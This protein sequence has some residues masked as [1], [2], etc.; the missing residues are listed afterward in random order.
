[1]CNNN[2]WNQVDTMQKH[3]FTNTIYQEQ[4]AEEFEKPRHSFFER[5]VYAEDGQR[6]SPW[7]NKVI[8]SHTHQQYQIAIDF[9]VINFL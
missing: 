5:I 3:D 2:R 9:L 8:K 4:N 1:M 7:M 6:K